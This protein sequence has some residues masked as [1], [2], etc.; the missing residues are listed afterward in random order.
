MTLKAIAQAENV[1]FDSNAII[2]FVERDD[3]LRRK[4]GGAFQIIEDNKISMTTS[5]IAVAE[6]L[7][8]AHKLK[9]A[10]LAADYRAL[11]DDI[12]AF[13]LVP[14]TRDILERAARL[15]PE[16]AMKLVDAIHFASSIAAGC[17]LLLTNDRKF[18]SGHGVLV[19]QISDL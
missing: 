8:G 6:C 12:K 5:E 9:S 19:I 7:Y 13:N 2:Y 1:Y 16:N 14:V 10:A 11:F 3:D 17:D 18:R 4:I 15:A